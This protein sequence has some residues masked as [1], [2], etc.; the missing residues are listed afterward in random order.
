MGF[1]FPVEKEDYSLPLEEERPSE[2]QPDPDFPK[3]SSNLRIPGFP[4]FSRATVPA[5]YKCV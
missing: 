2:T 5:Q 1:K 3:T 4:M